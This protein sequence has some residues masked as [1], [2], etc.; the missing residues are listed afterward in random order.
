VCDLKFGEYVYEPEKATGFDFHLLRVKL[1]TGDR[2]PPVQDM[3]SNIAVFADNAASSGHPDWI[4]QSPL[5]PARMGNSNF[6]IYW[7]V[8]C[9]TQPEHRAEQL[10]Y[11][12]DVDRH[13]LGVW[14]NSQYFADQ[15]HCTCPRCNELWKKSGLSWFEWRRKEITGYIAQIREHVKKEL[16]MCIQ[17]DPVNSYERYGVDFDDLAKYADA[18]NVVMFSK[19]YATPWYW[20]MLARAFKKLLKKPVYISL[21]VFGPGDNAKDVPSVSELL[22]V[23]IRCARTGIDGILYLASGP[24]QIKDFQKAVV[25]KVEL[26][27]RLQNY[28]GQPVQEVLDLFRSWEKIVE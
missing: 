6:N 23:S 4:S 22:T 10:D 27:D 17:P 5:G 26:R 8:V 24:S 3:Y 28:G 2:I 16:V 1:E 25:D 19:S 20:E 15:G 21:Y 9:A 13:S 12:E 11:I 7:D 18:F 14:L